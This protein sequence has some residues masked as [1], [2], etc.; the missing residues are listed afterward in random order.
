MV[1]TPNHDGE[2]G[3]RHIRRARLATVLAV[4]A[5][6]AA[7]SGA[8]ATHA[9]EPPDRPLFD[10]G[11]S[12]DPDHALMCEILERYDAA[13]EHNCPTEPITATSGPR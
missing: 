8:A 10:P 1:F 7:T 5:V 3:R 13:D 12:W 9:A 2:G 11:P 4:G 6:A